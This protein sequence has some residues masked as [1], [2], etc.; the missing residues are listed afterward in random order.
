MLRGRRS[1][2]S[3]AAVVALLGAACSN[4]VSSELAAAAVVE[5]PEGSDCYDPP[6]APGDG[7]MMSV[8]AGDFFFDNFAGE[9]A[10]GDIAVQMVNVAPATTHNIVFEGANTGSDAPIEANGGGEAEGTVNLF[11]GEYTFYCSIPGH[12]ASGMEGTLTV[13]PEL[14]DVTEVVTAI[15]LEE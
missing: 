1:L 3:A 7:G 2:L 4:G 8:D 15:G 13:T 10:E 11:V 14:T 5:C 9:V 12:R 6:R